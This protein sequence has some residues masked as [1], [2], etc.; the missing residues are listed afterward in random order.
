MLSFGSF[1]S[2]LELRLRW[3]PL[4]PSSQ[5]R[6]GS[7]ASR[8][9]LAAFTPLLFNGRSRE[10][11]H[12][13]P[14]R[15]SLPGAFHGSQVPRLSRPGMGPRGVSS[16]RLRGFALV[17]ARPRRHGDRTDG[18]AVRLRPVRRGIF[19]AFRRPRGRPPLCGG[20]CGV[21]RDL[22]RD[23]EYA[24]YDSKVVAKCPGL[25]KRV[26]LR[27]AV[28]EGAKR[29]IPIIAYCVVQQ[30]GHYLDQHP[31]FDMRGGDGAVIPGRYCLNSGYKESLK[32]LTSELIGYGIAGFHIDMLDQGFGR[33]YGCWC[34]TCRGLFEALALCIPDRRP[35]ECCDP[36]RRGGRPVHALRA[37]RRLAHRDGLDR[38]ARLAG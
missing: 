38:D 17:P 34:E 30:G 16:R 1:S 26:V 35:A 23:G 4:Q 11:A 3:S 24:Y 18:R 21:R 12:R 29:G 6:L 10:R 31:E 28:E 22:A 7:G 15:P 36:L 2:H 37:G 20:R 27:E 9:P 8:R 33:P 25:G 5:S 13:P 32:S 14:L 19:G